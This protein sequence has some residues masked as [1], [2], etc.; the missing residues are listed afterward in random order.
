MRLNGEP[1]E[2]VEC[3]IIWG[4]KWQRMEDV[5]GMWYTNALRGER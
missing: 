2:E 1:L 5:E 4:R 3:L